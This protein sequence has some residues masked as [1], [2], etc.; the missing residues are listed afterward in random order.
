[1]GVKLSS[2]ADY[3]PSIAA[4]VEMQ[5]E[6][7]YVAGEARESIANQLYGVNRAPREGY[8]GKIFDPEKTKAIQRGLTTIKPRTA[9]AG[10]NQS[11]SA[12]IFSV[13]AEDFNKY[14]LG[15]SQRGIREQVNLYLD[16]QNFSPAFREKYRISPDRDGKL[17]FDQVW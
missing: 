13:A 6:Q 3:K 5:A 8:G 7:A 4:N 16:Y 1:M 12:G 17:D 2:A 14:I 15:E 10:L 9:P 11:L